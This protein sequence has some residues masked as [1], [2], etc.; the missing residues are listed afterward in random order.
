[1]L[2]SFLEIPLPEVGDR[3]VFH[4]T[5]ARYPSLSA[6]PEKPSS[7][8]PSSSPSSAPT[9]GAPLPPGVDVAPGSDGKIGSGAYLMRADSEPAPSGTGNLMR[10][11]REKGVPERVW[12]HTTEEIFKTIRGS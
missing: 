2:I 9:T 10:G 12:R 6:S 11:Y 4:A 8:N 7:S 1:P 5:S 3:Q